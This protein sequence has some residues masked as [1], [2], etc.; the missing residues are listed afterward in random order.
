ML[1]RAFLLALVASLLAAA[2]GGDDEKKSETS[3]KPEVEV[4]KGSPPTALQIKDLKKGT[5]AEATAGKQVQVHYVGVAYSTKKQ[6]DSS[7]DRGNP[8]AF[9][10]GTR[11][12]IK[13]WEEGIPGMK[14]GGRRQ[15]VIPPDLA[16]GPNGF[17]PAIGPNETL[18]FVVDLV[19][20]S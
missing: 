9:P 11:K 8:I 1:R 16:Y 18:V 3:G 7:W 17:P 15:L 20:V 19:S 12:V 2:C 4:P 14:V 10:L 13:G 6:F 5:G